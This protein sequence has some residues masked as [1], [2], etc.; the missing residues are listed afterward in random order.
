VIRFNYSE[1]FAVVEDTGKLLFVDKESGAKPNQQKLIENLEK[2]KKNTYQEVLDIIKKETKT[3]IEKYYYTFITDGHLMI[4]VKE[5]GLETFVKVFYKFESKE[6]E[7]TFKKIIGIGDDEGK[8][9][10]GNLNN[11]FNFLTANPILKT[12]LVNSDLKSRKEEPFRKFKLK[13]KNGKIRD[14]IAPHEEI[15]APL[16]E[17]NSILQKIF[18]KTNIDFQIAYKK[19]KNIKQNADIHKTKQFIYNIDLKDFYPSCKRDLVKKYIKIFFR[20]SANSEVLENE[21]LDIVLD[22]DAL[23]IGSPISG[24]LANAIIS[25][26]VRY[27]KN[28]TAKFGMEFSVYADDMTFSSDRFISEEFILN[29]FN[30]AF[31]RYNLD[32]YFKL[33]EKKSHGM[34]KNKRRVTGVSLN[35]SNQTVVSRKFYRNLRVKI[36]KLS[37]GD[38]TINLQKLRGQLAFATMVDDSG[39]ILRLLENFKEVVSNFKLINSEKLEELRKKGG[40]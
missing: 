33:N 8:V 37:L 19:G 11:S 6:I 9:I 22:N 29:I 35:D 38:M 3:K 27:I 36:H 15:K 24:T 20:N 30:L 10:I 28:I 21:F 13:S 18:D 5:F 7:E 2:F 25:R 34:S 26:P 14:I 31:I 16:K 39:K 40:V 1:K 12:I 4:A 17:L 32:N 23:F